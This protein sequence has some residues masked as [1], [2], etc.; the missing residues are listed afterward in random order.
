MTLLSRFHDYT[1][2]FGLLREA[3]HRGIHL[4][5]VLGLIFLVYGA[6]RPAADAAPPQS[7]PGRPGGVPLLDWLLALAVAATALYIPGSSPTS[8][9]ASARRCRSTS[10]SAAR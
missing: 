2:G 3:T 6:R 5:L 9:S 8:P 1:A 4:A 7:S 10:P